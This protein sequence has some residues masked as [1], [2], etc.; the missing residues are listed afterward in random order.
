MSFNESHSGKNIIP[1]QMNKINKNKE[2][3]YNTFKNR[4]FRTEL[5]ITLL[6]T[7]A[8]LVNYIE[9]ILIKKGYDMGDCDGMYCLINSIYFSMYGQGINT[10]KL[11]NMIDLMFKKN[12]SFFEQNMDYYNSWNQFEVF[13]SNLKKIGLDLKV[14]FKLPSENEFNNKTVIIHLSQNHFSGIFYQRCRY[15]LN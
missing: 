13:K 11:F 7:P 4:L 9:E 5:S 14:V 12:M 15:L 8:V 6:Q 1:F 3:K 2:I 10:N